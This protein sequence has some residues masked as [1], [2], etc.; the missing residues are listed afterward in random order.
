MLFVKAGGSDAS[1]DEQRAEADRHFVHTPNA[2]PGIRMGINPGR[3]PPVSL[4]GAR[5]G[6]VAELRNGTRMELNNVWEDCYR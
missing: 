4:L 3:V 5:T 6:G 1:A 2:L